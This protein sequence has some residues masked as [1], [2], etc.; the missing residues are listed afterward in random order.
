M[1]K[2]L[3]FHKSYSYAFCDTTYME[4]VIVNLYEWCLETLNERILEEWHLTKNGE[5]KPCDVAAKSHRKVW[6]KCKKDH[7]WEA[8]VSSRTSGN[9]CPICYQERRKQGSKEE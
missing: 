1:R 8:V 3:T 9:G 6:W 2:R 7:E 4:D 5:L